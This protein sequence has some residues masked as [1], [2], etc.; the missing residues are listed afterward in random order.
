MNCLRISHQDNFSHVRI[1]GDELS[2]EHIPAVE[3]G[4]IMGKAEN[5]PVVWMWEQKLHPT[6]IKTYVLHLN[7]F[8]TDLISP[9]IQS[10][11][12]HCKI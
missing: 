8:C 12:L 10:S 3:K 6:T 9:I 5:K 11:I 7:L 1:F 4:W 2:F